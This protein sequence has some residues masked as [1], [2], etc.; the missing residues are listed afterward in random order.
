M[1]V[2]LRPAD[3]KKCSV[4]DHIVGHAS[5]LVSQK[6]RLEFEFAVTEYKAF[7][8]VETLFVQGRNLYLGELQLFGGK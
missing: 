3:A 4:R 6:M 1:K 7:R 5:G 2:P 8:Y